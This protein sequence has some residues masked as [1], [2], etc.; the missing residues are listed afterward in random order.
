MGNTLRYHQIWK[1]LHPSTLTTLNPENTLKFSISFYAW[2]AK[3]VSKHGDFF[4]NPTRKMF[5]GKNMGKWVW[6]V[7][8]VEAMRPSGVSS[9]GMIGLVMVLEDL[10]EV[11]CVWFFFWVGCGRWWFSCRGRNFR[12]RQWKIPARPMLCSTVQ[13][14]LNSEFLFF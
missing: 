5:S 2:P 4:F 13:I 8:P 14:E 3:F 1:F 11:L 10:R 7:C 9:E 6:L 12:R